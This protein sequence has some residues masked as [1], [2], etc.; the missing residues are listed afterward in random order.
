VPP[1]SEYKNKPCGEERATGVPI[2]SVIAQVSLLAYI[3]YHFSRFILFSMKT[4]AAGSAE[5]LVY[6]YQRIHHHIPRDC[7]LNINILSLIYDPTADWYLEDKLCLPGTFTDE[8]V[9]TES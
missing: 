3:T 1:S 8:A 6:I 4:E 7:Y 2:D 9:P 5:A